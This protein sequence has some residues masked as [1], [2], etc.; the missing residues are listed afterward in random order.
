MAELEAIRLKKLKELVARAGKAQSPAVSHPIE[1]VDANVDETI[2]RH[3]FVVVDCW[4]PWCGPCRMLAPVIEDMARDYAGKIVF[5]KL[6]VDH[7]TL[8]ANRYRIE[9]IPT[10]LILA[11]GREVGR[12]I[13]VLPRAEIDR[14][15]KS[16][17]KQ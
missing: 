2:S 10:L 4:A 12:I 11:D 14:K 8:T 15:L 9:S 13:G 6:N 7:N 17:L 16:Y 5:A 1:V 3:S